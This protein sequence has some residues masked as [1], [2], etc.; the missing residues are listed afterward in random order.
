[1]LTKNPALM[2]QYLDALLKHSNFTKAA[3]DLYI[4][5][6]YLTQ[7]IKR[8]EQELGVAIIDRQNQQLHLSEA[9]KIYY[10]YLEKQNAENAALSQQLA[11]YT[12]T[13]QKILKLGVL[14][15][16]GSFL[17]PLFLPKFLTNH[18]HVKI[19]LVEN[20]PAINEK[21]IINGELDFWLGQNPETVDPTLQLKTV[22]TE[23]YLAV[24]PDNSKLYDEKK[25]QLPDGSIPIKMLLHEPLVLSTTDS[26]I[27]HQVDALLSKYKITPNIIIESQN[28]VTAA[29]LAAHG[30]GITIVPASVAKKITPGNYNFYYLPNHLISLRYFIAF[31]RIRTLSAP[32]KELIQAFSAIKNTTK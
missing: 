20:P 9:G 15:S 26:A 25:Q 23:D 31:Q 4:S 6:P 8:I 30:M 14:S 13:D 29:E 27:R 2:L 32:E 5:Q 3:K 17:L 22:G 21:L 1:M 7:T 16:L 11:R 12:Q 10:R 24:I 28:I 19:V 18:P